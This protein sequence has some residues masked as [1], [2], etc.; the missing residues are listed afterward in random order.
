MLKEL[1][2]FLIIGIVFSATSTKIVVAPVSNTL[3]K[4]L[5]DTDYFSFSLTPDGEAVAFTA[6]DLTAKLTLGG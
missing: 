3:E 2:S 6:S 4:P 1:I 5:A